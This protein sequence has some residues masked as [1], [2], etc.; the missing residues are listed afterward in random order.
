M[1]EKTKC[2]HLKTKDN[3]VLLPPRGRSYY[4]KDTGCLKPTVQV[5]MEYF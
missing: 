4:P 2:D 5:K 1:F 3:S